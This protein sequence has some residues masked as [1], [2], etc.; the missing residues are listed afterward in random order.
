MSLQILDV[1]SKIV[2]EQTLNPENIGLKDIIIDLREFESGT[3]TIKIS[4]QIR[5]DQKRFKKK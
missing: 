5:S 1:S 4:D 2:F 3:S